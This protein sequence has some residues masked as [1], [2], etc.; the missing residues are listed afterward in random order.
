MVLCSQ[1]RESIGSSWVTVV[2]ST[3]VKLHPYIW[4]LLS[5]YCAVMFSL[6]VLKSK[7]FLFL[8]FLEC[9]AHDVEISGVSDVVNKPGEQMGL[10]WSSCV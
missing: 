4:I 5:K 8:D 10:L 3:L 7:V 1:A 9:V 6:P 2:L